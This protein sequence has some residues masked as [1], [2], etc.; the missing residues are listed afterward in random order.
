VEDIYNCVPFDDC[1]VA[2]G[3]PVDI[4]DP[5]GSFGLFEPPRGHHYEIPYRC[6]L[7]LKVDNLLVAGRCVSATHEALGAIRVMPFCFGMGEAAGTAAAISIQ[8]G[9]IPKKVD[10]K[11]LQ[12]VLA[13]QGAFIPR[14]SQ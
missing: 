14:I 8:D 2:A 9:V 4:H 5:A 6:L 3:F 1:V 7:P 11:K 10:T 13:E 12:K